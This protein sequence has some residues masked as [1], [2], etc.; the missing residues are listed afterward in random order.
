MTFGKWRQQLRLLHSIQK[1]A[2]GEKVTTVALDAGY[3]S[4][5]AFISV[6]RKSMGITPGQYID[7][8]GMDLFCS[9]PL[10]IKQNVCTLRTVDM[11][12]DEFERHP[13]V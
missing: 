7:C 11:V 1:L 2:S 10:V 3:N 5:S 12:M 4:T 9:T 8:A 13:K 6:F